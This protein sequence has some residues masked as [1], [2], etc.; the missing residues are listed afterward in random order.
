MAKI[1]KKYFKQSL[2][3]FGLDPFLGYS[4]P[5]LIPN[6][7]TYFIDQRCMIVLDPKE[8]LAFCRNPKV[9]SSTWLVR[10]HSLLKNIPPEKEATDMKSINE[11]HE[12][13]HQ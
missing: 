4:E 9:G 3:K 1:L 13:A 8:K 2:L 12:D 6:I 11:Y 5:S 7:N 10:F